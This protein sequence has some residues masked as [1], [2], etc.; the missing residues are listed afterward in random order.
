MFAEVSKHQPDPP[1]PRP[2]VTHIAVDGGESLVT[3]PLFSRGVR[4]MGIPTKFP[5]KHK[6]GH[7]PL[8]DLANN[9]NDK[10]NR[11]PTKRE[12]FATWLSEKW[13]DPDDGRDCGKCFKASRNKDTELNERQ[14][15]L[16]IEEFDTKYQLPEL[17]GTEKMI[18]S[19]LVD[20][21]R[22]DRYSILSLLFDSEQ[23]QH[24][25]KHG[26]L[27]DASRVLDWAGFWTN[28]LGFKVRKDRDYGQD[29]FVEILIDGAAEEA[30]RKESAT[31]GEHI[32]TE[33][34]Y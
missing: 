20:S 13:S 17:R 6:C 29:E 10:L 7:S 15:M 12:G 2:L 26:D 5:V 16:D 24:T 18:D 11:G 19:G 27:L 4:A 32:E 33:N 30:K 34:P 3:D 1:E 21:A 14:W 8:I 25:D 9:R 31:D 22:K 28:H 23:S